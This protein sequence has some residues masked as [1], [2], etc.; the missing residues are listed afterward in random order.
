VRQR[1]LSARIHALRATGTIPSGKLEQALTARGLPCFPLE[2]ER[3]ERTG[4][5]GR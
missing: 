4:A 3:F 1:Q 5:A 2:I